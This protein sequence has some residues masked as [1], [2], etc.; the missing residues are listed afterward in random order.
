MAGG[1]IGGGGGELLP[2]KPSGKLLA[3]DAAVCCVW[4]WVWVGAGNGRVCV[5]VGVCGCAGAY[6]HEREKESACVVSSARST[7]VW[8]I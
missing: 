4:A 5:C 7:C 3:I 6:V 1:G 2:A 8:P